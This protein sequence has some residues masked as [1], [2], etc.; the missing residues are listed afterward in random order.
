MRIA[1]M[2]STTAAG[3]QRIDQSLWRSRTYSCV[4]SVSDEALLAGLAA[5]DREA[6]AAF[7]RRFQGRVY[8]L[9]LTIVRDPAAAEDVA[10]ETFVRVWRNAESFDPRRGR[11]VPWLLTIA[12]NLAVDAGRMRRADPIDPDVLAGSIQLAGSAPAADEID[13]APDE[14]ERLRAAIAALPADQ[15]QALV[16]AAYLGRT[17]REIG[18]LDDVPLGTVKTRIRAAMLKLRAELE[19]SHGV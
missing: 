15:R 17:A 2:P 8:G 4:W 16:Q 19:G 11:V 5:G 14:R 6:A 9:A 12:R 13:P 18:E 10:Q 3:A 1:F 7:V